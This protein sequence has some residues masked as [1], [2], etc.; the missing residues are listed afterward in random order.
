MSTGTERP[1]IV[2]ILAEDL[3]VKLLRSH[4]EDYPNIK[5]LAD[6]GIGFSRSFVSESVCCPSRATSLTG[7]Y[8]HNHGVEQAPGEEET[9]FRDVVQ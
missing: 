7:L 2:F 9:S 4:M 1:N 3:S 6:E 5:T 8:R